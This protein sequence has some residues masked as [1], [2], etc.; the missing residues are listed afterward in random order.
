MN[1]EKILAWCKKFL[2]LLIENWRV[3]YKEIW[4]RVWR[5]TVEWLRAA[6]LWLKEEGPVVA[7]KGWT[8]AVTVV[9]TAA[10]T[11]L[12]V[13]APY[14]KTAGYTK[15]GELEAIIVGRF[16]GDVDRVALEDAAANAMVEVLGDRWSYYIPAD[17]Y[18][19]YLEQKQNVY[20]GIGVT[21]KRLD[22]GSGLEVTQL[23]Q[24]GSAAE[25]GILAGDHIV[26]VD[27]QRLTG[28]S[29]E[30]AKALIRGEVGSKVDLTIYRGGTERVISVTRKQIV[31]PVAAGRMVSDTIGV[32]AIKNFNDHCASETIAVIEDLQEQG[33]EKLIFD[34]RFNPGGYVSELVAVLDYLLP[35]CLLFRSEDFMGNEDERYSDAAY[36]DMP[37][38]VLVNKSS[39]SAAEFFAAALSEYDAAVIVGEQTSGKGFFQ[40]T[41]ELSDGSAIGLSVGRYFT[42]KG[43]SLEGVGLTPDVAVP[44][45]DQ[46]SAGIQNGIIS[47]ADDRQLQAA[48]SALE[49]E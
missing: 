36:L 37:M 26:A 10:V 40:N 15:L 31:T 6:W 1:K 49:E 4:P 27:G 7:K 41:Y 11:A 48:I 24:E 39:Y 32:V 38:A 21:I 13:M 34:V 47:D 35:E 17:E 46:T 25:A 30:D 2:R 43:V 8:Y 45:N 44:L 28:M 42:P 23:T 9:V 5:K 22:D 3:F 16:I 29:L 19:A 14:F 20:V 18:A 12:I 33:A